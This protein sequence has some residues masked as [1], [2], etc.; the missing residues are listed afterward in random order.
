M[1]SPK[2][3]LCVIR[4]GGDIG[5]GVVW[6]LWRS[7]YSVIVTELPNPLT[8]RRTVSMS[9]AVAEGTVTVESMVGVKVDSQQD[10]QQMALSGRQVPV[11]VSEALLDVAADVVIDARL[12]KRNIDTSITDAP[13]VVAL[14]PGFTARTDC[15][16]VVETMRGHGLGR[17]I[18]QGSALANTGIPA[19]VNG[20]AQ[21]RVL[22][23][24]LAGPTTWVVEIG[25]KVK[26]NQ[27]LGQVGGQPITAPFDGVIRGLIASGTQVRSGLKIGDVDPR[28]DVECHQISDKALAIGGGVL[29]A[30]TGWWFGAR[31]AND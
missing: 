30:V 16:V 25:T 3:P 11:I 27:V 13:L 26:T 15:D 23:A 9:T 28:L 2:P 18:W 12:A 14:G 22:R 6:R 5:T 20:H 7:G 29:E 10:A 31:S 8:V 1:T 21:S 17:T 4:G 24:P 19:P